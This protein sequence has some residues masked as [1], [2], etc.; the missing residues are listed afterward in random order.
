M[1]LQNSICY[2]VHTCI[3]NIAA[4]PIKN[5]CT[6]FEF[7]KPGFLCETPMLKNQDFL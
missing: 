6:V 3:P 4:N 1:H 5:Y 2:A 7:G